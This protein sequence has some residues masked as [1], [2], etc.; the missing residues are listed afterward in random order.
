MKKTGPY[1]I[2]FPIFFEQCKMQ[3]SRQKGLTNVYTNTHLRM[4]SVHNIII[5]KYIP[6]NVDKTTC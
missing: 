4:L 3:Y 2:N 6:H 5:N 1:A